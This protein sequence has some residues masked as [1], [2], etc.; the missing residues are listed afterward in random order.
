M[1]RILTLLSILA[2]VI[3]VALC[4]NASADDGKVVIDNVVY[5]LNTK[6]YL[7]EKYGEH[8]VV[9]DYFDDDSLISETTKLKIV[10]E[11]DGIEVKGIDHYSDYEESVINRICLPNTIKYVGECAFGYFPKLEKI[12]LPSGLESIGQHCFQGLK[13]LKSISIPA[14]LKVINGYA[15]YGCTNLETV[16]FEGDLIGIEYYAFE[17][18]INLSSVEFPDS[19]EYIGEEAFR[20]CNSLKKVVIPAKT[21]I[22]KKAFEYCD[23]L[24]KLVIDYGKSNDKGEIHIADAFDGCN[25]KA[26]Y[27]KAIPE[28][29]YFDIT[30]AEA[31]DIKNIYFAG[32]PSLWNKYTTKEQRD[33]FDKNEIE[34]H[35]YY[36][37]THSFTRNGD[38]TCTKGGKFTYKCDCGD[39]QTVT[40][41]KDPDNHSYGSWKV[42]KKAT[43]AAVGTK[44]RTCKYCGKV[45][46]ATVK[47]LVFGELE[48]LTATVNGNDVV[49]NWDALE[50]ATGYR[51][52]IYDKDQN[53]NIKLASFKG[54][55]TYT[56]SDLEVGETYTFRVKPYNKTADGKVIWSKSF[57]VSATI[58]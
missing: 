4:F 28:K 22:S 51:I 3:T 55:T 11:I 13:S 6:D 37:H 54:K 33:Y 48:N 34:V 29:Y 1:K 24:E 15:F 46:K 21:K 23:S 8:Y 31:G 26:I 39:T 52:Y 57:A 56:I 10:D 43:Y 9:T 42:T 50:G 17:N 35:F 40:L 32:S 19:L 27:L 5:E 38:P 47:K 53:K 36:K 12:I 7:N 41:P 2:L 20:N 44:Q 49:L 16:T 14:S 18:C 45:Q 25:L 30:F 58:Q